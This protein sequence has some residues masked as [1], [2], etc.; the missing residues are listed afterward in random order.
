V[1][2]K[3]AVKHLFGY[4]VGGKSLDVKD[5]ELLIGNNQNDKQLRIFDLKNSKLRTL[6]WNNYD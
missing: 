6:Q 5:N 1:R 4:H 2:T 3:T